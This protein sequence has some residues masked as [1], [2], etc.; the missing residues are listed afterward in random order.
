MADGGGRWLRGI[1]MTK[2][3]TFRLNEDDTDLLHL[4]EGI[5]P[6]KRSEVIREMLRY[7]YLKK[8][9]EQK[10]GGPL[11]RLEEMMADLSRRFQALE[12]KLVN[13]AVIHQEPKGVV[14]ETSI[15][16]NAQ[17]F[18]SAFGMD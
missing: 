1:H 15:R 10:G 17:S 16:K 8:M 14:D 11:S 7:A 2:R 4:L 6:S 9:E 12:E 3:Y 13:G 18:L 5:P